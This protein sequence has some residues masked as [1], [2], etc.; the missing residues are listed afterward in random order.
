MLGQV[1]LD[2]LPQDFLVKEVHLDALGLGLHATA[3]SRGRCVVPPMLAIRRW[4]HSPRA[5]GISSP[6]DTPALV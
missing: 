6:A 5:R 1:G 3:P 4:K 2:L